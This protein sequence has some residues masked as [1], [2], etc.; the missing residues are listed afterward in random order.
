MT[1]LNYGDIVDCIAGKHGAPDLYGRCIYC[2]EQLLTTGI[3][4]PPENV[5]KAIGD[6]LDGKLPHAETPPRDEALYMLR[7]QKLPAI[8]ASTKSVDYIDGPLAGLTA[9]GV[10]ENATIIKD[11]TVTVNDDPVAGT[12]FDPYTTIT[13]Y[14]RVHGDRGY[15]IWQH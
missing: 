10:P 6:F 11:V 5:N 15:L 4:A 13:V 8:E 3:Q 14:Y 2:D 1:D 12:F 9:F 7:A